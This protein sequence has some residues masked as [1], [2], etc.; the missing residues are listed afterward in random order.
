MAD[1]TGALPT[2]SFDPS[3]MQLVNYGANSANLINPT[4]SEG[5]NYYLDS[6]SGNLYDANG[7][8][9]AS[10]EA[11]ALHGGVG[12]YQQEG[13]TDGGE[14]GG[15]SGN[16]QF[17]TKYNLDV[18]PTQIQADYD[19]KQKDPNAYNTKL[20]MQYANI[21]AENNGSNQLITSLAQ[22]AGASND[23]INS[24]LAKPQEAL[25]AMK[26]TDPKAY[27]NAI[28]SKAAANAAFQT[29]QNGQANPEF[30]NAM[31]KAFDDA[32]NAGVS[33][34]QLN[35]I[36][37]NIYQNGIKTQ[38]Q[39]VAQMDR[40]NPYFDSVKFIAPL[41][42]GGLGIDSLLG[43]AA[44]TGG[45]GL[46][47][48]ADVGLEGSTSALTD[49]S[50]NLGSQAL[51]SLGL[52]TSTIA[53]DALSSAT[54]A[55]PNVYNNAAAI[56]AA[57]ATSDPI[58][59]L[60]SM[61]GLTASELAIAT[62]PAG[63]GLTAAQIASAASLV[64]TG[65][66]VAQAVKAVANAVSPSKTSGGGS[67]SGS[68][69]GGGSSSG[70]G[71]DYTPSGKLPT[72]LTSH[73]LAGAAVSNANPDLIRRLQQMDPRILKSLGIQLPIEVA[74]HEE[75]PTAPL[76]AA[77]SQA[78]LNEAN[79]GNPSAG[80][81]VAKEG[82]SYDDI[83]NRHHKEHKPEFITGA[84]GHYVRGKGD[85]QSDDIPAMLAD[86][87]YVFDADTV[88]QLGNGSSD[89]GAKLLDHFRESLRE[90]K[91]SA[92]SDKIPP[93]ASPLNYMKEALKRHSKG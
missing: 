86:G 25:E 23:Q 33:E 87:E 83:I 71:S 36:Y 10:K 30:D 50:G 46:G 92:P 72:A 34:E 41:A 43:A 18:D 62:T 8:V 68:S 59:A 1:T 51:D 14:S 73:A 45:G 39:R 76:S 78:T 2:D 54:S 16:G 42:L 44:A 60:A 6:N 77:M 67:S 47:G 65:V 64:K 70:S 93:K 38:S 48:L 5:T 7:N 29:G 20:A 9:A 37:T 55:L 11:L 91:R 63:A 4:E 49:L 24:M 26:T 85:G 12:S 57:N 89:A 74:Q 75:Q 79:M 40:S 21:G 58:G 80:I 35:N 15:S 31:Y 88:A 56:A 13:R 27:A 69:S 66:S 3:K 81:P 17:T 22:K 61:D 84:T 19:L 53:G 90:H 28:A 82:G 32:R 52:N